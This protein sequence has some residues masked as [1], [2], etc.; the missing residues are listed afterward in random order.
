MHNTE[1]ESA[2][3]VQPGKNLSFVLELTFNICFESEL[4]LQLDLT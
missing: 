2:L 3:R 4:G 1:L